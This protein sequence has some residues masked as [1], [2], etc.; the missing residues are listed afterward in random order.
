[1]K[2]KRL[3]PELLIFTTSITDETMWNNV[4]PPM[5]IDWFEVST[6]ANSLTYTTGTLEVSE[7]D[8][9]TISSLGLNNAY[10][11]DSSIP[12]TDLAQYVVS[13]ASRIN[14]IQ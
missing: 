10:T 14:F 6:I 1:M 11:L 9:K 3:Q 2:I 4:D 8:P 7:M 12:F 13:Q 5:T